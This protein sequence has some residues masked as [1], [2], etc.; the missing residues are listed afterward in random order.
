MNEYFIFEYDKITGLSRSMITDE[1]HY[2]L[3]N[4]LDGGADYFPYWT[5]RKGD[6]WIVD[7]DAFDFKKKHNEEFLSKSVAIHPE[8][9]EKLRTFCKRP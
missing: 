4:D 1:D 2:G 8:M 3:I 5:N 7:D 6:I 9:K